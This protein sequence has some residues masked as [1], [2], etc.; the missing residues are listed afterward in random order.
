MTPGG[1]RG[2][3]PARLTCTPVS[4]LPLPVSRYRPRS[5]PC[6]GFQDHPQ[7]TARAVLRCI[8]RAAGPYDL[9]RLPDRTML[10]APAR[11][12]RPPR[13]RPLARCALPISP[14]P[15]WSRSAAYSGCGTGCFAPSRSWCPSPRRSARRTS[16]RRKHGSI[17]HPKRAKC[18]N[19]NGQNALSQSRQ[20]S[21]SNWFIMIFARPPETAI[22]FILSD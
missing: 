2:S 9:R 6:D 17:L 22:L 16:C 14:A 4:V 10:P 3:R 21:P 11:S 20:N 1:C 5:S 18:V 15:A 7:T 8:S 12:P 19:H 13:R